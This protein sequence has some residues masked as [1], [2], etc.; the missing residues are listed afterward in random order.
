MNLIIVYQYLF[1]DLMKNVRN[2][3]TKIT[4]MRAA[5]LRKEF[6]ESRMKYKTVE[7]LKQKYI[8]FIS[9]KTRFT[10]SFSLPTFSLLWIKFLDCTIARVFDYYGKTSW[11][12]SL[13][14]RFHVC[15]QK[16]ILFVS[17][18]LRDSCPN[19]S[20]MFAWHRDQTTL[21]SQGAE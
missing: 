5:W 13:L 12:K 21:R 18:F 7:I 3:F 1:M 2:D 20:L 14:N 17:V 15:L 10:L 4:T 16:I 6:L 11:R 8:T 9:I 19:S